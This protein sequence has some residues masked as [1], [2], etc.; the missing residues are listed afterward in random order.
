MSKSDE[1]ATRTIDMFSLFIRA[2]LLAD[3]TM[4]RRMALLGL[5]YSAG[6]ALF[7]P[8][9]FPNFPGNGSIYIG[10]GLYCLLASIVYGYQFVRIR[11]AVNYYRAAGLS[12][13]VRDVCF[14]LVCFA[15]VAQCVFEYNGLGIRANQ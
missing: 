11:G 1:E 2:W 6:S 5:L 14:M 4:P 12:V 13:A 3:P 15:L 9:V 10:V 8:I 7:V